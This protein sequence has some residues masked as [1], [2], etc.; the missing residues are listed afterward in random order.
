MK[1]L[2]INISIVLLFVLLL[3]IDAAANEEASYRDFP[4]LYDD[5]EY[6]RVDDA[7][8]QGYL[9]IAAEAVNP[10][11]LYSVN[12]GQLFMLENKP[13]KVTDKLSEYVWLLPLSDGTNRRVRVSENG[14]EVLGGRTSSLNKSQEDIDMDAGFRALS[15]YLQERETDFAETDIYALEVPEFYT[16]FLLCEMADRS[17]VIPFSDASHLTQLEGGRIY[18]VEEAIDI[19]KS[20]F[21][22]ENSG[23][24]IG[25]G[26]VSAGTKRNLSYTIPTISA[27][28]LAVIMAVF[29][30]QRSRAKRQ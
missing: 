25:N 9:S 7:V 10:Y 18:S 24:M 3:H 29:L 15:A 30:I 12:R 1:T 14:V 21:S 5:E 11:K 13:E 16:S 6:A 28:A 8:R 19:L 17:V 20:A 22:A 26:G 4:T 23:E 27:A 2:L